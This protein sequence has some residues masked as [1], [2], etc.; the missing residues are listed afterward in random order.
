[1]HLLDPKIYLFSLIKHWLHP[2]AAR[3]FR[4]GCSF[5]GYDGRLDTI[6]L[7]PSP[8][9]AKENLLLKM[10][11]NLIARYQVESQ[12]RLPDLLDADEEM[13]DDSSDRGE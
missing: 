5:N 7:L 10:L 12:Y 8:E 9:I 4:L 1:M 6:F 3:K 2:D 13:E 11:Q